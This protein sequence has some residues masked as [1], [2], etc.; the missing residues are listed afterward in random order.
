MIGFN[1]KF[2]RKTDRFAREIFPN[3]GREMVALT[4]LEAAFL[5]RTAEAWEAW[6]LERDIPIAAVRNP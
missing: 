3:L 6:A 4:A 5:A 1:L 2:V